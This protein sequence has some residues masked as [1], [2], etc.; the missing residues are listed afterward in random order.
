MKPETEPCAELSVGDGLRLAYKAL[1]G[2]GPGVM[3][4]PGFNSDMQG[5]KAQA[6]ANW[7]TRR[8]RSFTRFDY[9]GHGRSGGSVAEG[10][11]GGWLSDTL[12]VL[13]RV[14]EGS[15]VLVGSSMGG[16]LALLAALARPQR[17]SGLLLIAPA[18]DFT[19]RLWQHGLSAQ[20][21]ADLE[22]NGACQV[23]SDYDEEPYTITRHLL[24]EA[25]QHCLPAAPIAIDVPVR[26]LQGQRDTAV[27][28]HQTVELMN[29]LASEDVEL[30]LLK[31]GDHRLSGEGE[32]AHLLQTLETLLMTVA[33]GAAGAV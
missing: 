22:A 15:Q 18:P 27:P 9:R 24:E 19:E 5:T 33:P 8:G 29:R 25:R 10:T 14:T 7:C 21:R 16:W 26:L 3:F 28:W 32:L 6:L 11:I 17:V 1:P 13:D 31:S 20:Q 30:L 4:C 12:A 23:D 2:R